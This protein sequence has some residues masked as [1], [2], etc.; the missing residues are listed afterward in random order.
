MKEVIYFGFSTFWKYDEVLCTADSRLE[1]SC[2][3]S[4]VYV[5]FA[6]RNWQVIYDGLC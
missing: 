5:A 4:D 6:I 1:E 3:D 2:L